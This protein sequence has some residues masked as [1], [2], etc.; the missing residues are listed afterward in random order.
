MENETGKREVVNRVFWLELD[1]GVRDRNKTGILLTY[2]RK[3]IFKYLKYLIPSIL[4][5]AK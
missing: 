3:F 4:I 2:T 5:E 1:D